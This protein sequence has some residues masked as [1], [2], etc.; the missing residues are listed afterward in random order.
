MADIQS[1]DP[2]ARRTAV[3][4]I[5][6]AGLVGFALIAATRSQLGALQKFLADNPAE[7]QANLRIITWALIAAVVVPVWAVNVYLWRLGSRSVRS[8]VFPPPGMPV[9]RDTIVLR[10]TAARKCGRML[11]ILAA[12]MSAAAA[13]FAVALWRLA[14]QIQRGPL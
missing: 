4:F 11:Q 2:R 12:V 9:I 1:A 7:I 14:A 13:G 3:I 10:D 6:A 5:A 8:G